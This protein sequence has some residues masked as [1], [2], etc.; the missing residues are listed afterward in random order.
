MPKILRY[1]PNTVKEID[2]ISVSE[3]A[4]ELTHIGHGGMEQDFFWL[5]ADHPTA[6]RLIDWINFKICQLIT[7]EPDNDRKIHITLV[8]QKQIIPKLQ[9]WGNDAIIDLE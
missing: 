6:G 7:N 1:E 3:I 8:L 2:R 4:C 9:Q 5:N